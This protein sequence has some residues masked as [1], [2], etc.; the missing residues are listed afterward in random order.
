MLMLI[1]YRKQKSLKNAHIII[2]D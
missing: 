2:D 1:K